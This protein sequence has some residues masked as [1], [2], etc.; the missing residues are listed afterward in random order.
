MHMA[1]RELGICFG[2]VLEV[3][4]MPIFSLLAEFQSSINRLNV[5]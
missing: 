5:A 2:L 1:N 4:G 3:L